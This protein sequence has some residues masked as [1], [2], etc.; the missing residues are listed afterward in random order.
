MEFRSGSCERF[1]LGFEGGLADHVAA[2]EDAD[3]IEYVGV[4]GGDRGGLR[5]IHRQARRMRSVLR[6]RRRDKCLT[7]LSANTLS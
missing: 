7:G 4:V 3:V 1:E 5:G 6:S 2:A